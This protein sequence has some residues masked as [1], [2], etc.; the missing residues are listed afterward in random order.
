MYIDNNDVRT[1]R[2]RVGGELLRQAREGDSCGCEHR[3]R[4][5]VTR[6]GTSVEDHVAR[7]LVNG[8]DTR[9]SMPT[10]ADT[11]TEHSDEHSDCGCDGD[12]TSYGGNRENRMTRDNEHSGC[13][14]GNERMTRDSEHSGCGCG[15]ERMTRDSERS[16]CGCGNERMIRNSWRSGYGRSDYRMTRTDTY[17]HGGC[18]CGT[19]NGSW[20]LHEHPLAIVYSPQQVWRNVYDPEEGM[21]HGTIFAELDL[22][23]YG[24]DNMRGGGC[25]G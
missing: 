2:E 4:T 21:E 11:D 8:L 3:N 17:E 23:F 7:S 12:N 22:P 18:G 15:N 16:G 10:Y 5:G 24:N 19:D 13:G 25:R 1:P 14:C 20:G 6:S 9:H